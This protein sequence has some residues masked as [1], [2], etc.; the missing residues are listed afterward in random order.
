MSGKSKK[1]ILHS[2]KFYN[3]LFISITFFF[4]LLWTFFLFYEGE[5]SRQFELF[6]RQCEDFFADAINVVGY[7]SLRDVYN[8]PINGLA[9]KA[10]PP[11][12]YFIMYFFSRLVNIDKYYEV[13]GFLEMYKEPKFLIM[14]LIYT[15]VTILLFYELIRSCKKGSNLIKKLTAFAIVLSAPFLFSL[16]RGNTVILTTFFVLFFIFYYDSTNKILKEFAL[17][18]LAMAVALKMTPAV[19]GILLLYNK[20]WKDAIKAVLYGI[21]IGVLPFFFFKGGISNLFLMIENIKVHFDAYTSAEGCTLLAIALHYGLPATETLSSVMKI[22]TYVVCLLFAVAAPLSDTVWE[23]VLCICMILIILPSHSGYYC[24]LYIIPAIIM[25]LNEDNHKVSDIIVLL[26]FLIILCPFQN[27]LSYMVLNYHFS[28]FLLVIVML[29]RSIYCIVLSFR[30]SNGKVIHLV[31]GFIEKIA[32]AVLVVLFKIIHKELTGEAFASFM[33]FVKFGLVG[34]SNTVISY[35]IYVCSLLFFQRM[36]VLP[37]I[38]YLVAQVI[39]FV[40]SV[41]WSFYW[42]NKL[43][44]VVEE[45][46]QRSIWRALL[47][48]YVSYSFTGLFLN[49]ILLVLWVDLLHMSEFLA[50]IF[51]L[52]INVPINFLINKFWAFK[53]K[54]KKISE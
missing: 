48:T 18:S 7:A 11:L 24:I 52:I 32:H 54:D 36:E 1:D 41:A 39:A 17:I 22:I 12:P 53:T 10:Y 21:V 25:F 13:G 16:E 33:Q 19:L 23:K 30:N 37:R 44:F 43:V 49:S 6:F 46:Q 20:Q 51:N 5:F 45:G 2:G 50:P 31:W 40:L 15:V 29:Y 38:D 42:N 26:S 4:F 35:A 28:L 9:E 27:S 47:K 8:N 34:V 3:V 14:F